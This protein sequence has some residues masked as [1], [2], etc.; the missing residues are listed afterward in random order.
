MTAR[1]FGFLRQPE[2]LAPEP[3]DS[4]VAERYPVGADAN[5]W[6]NRFLLAA[7][8]ST[9]VNRLIYMPFLAL[10]LLVPAR[11]QLFDAW[12][13]PLP[14]AAL[15]VVSLSLAVGCAMR[16]R[17]DA[18]ELR[19]QVLRQINLE[20]EK[21]EL[22]ASRRG[23][24]ANKKSGLTPPAYKAERLRS[25]ATEIRENHEGAFRPLLQEPVIRGI[26][27]LLGGAGGVATA[28]FLLLKS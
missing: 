8:L 15:F 16:L 21:F 6:I 25:M 5:R 11:S 4:E 17:L 28:E 20:A 2:T 23:D 14:H 7:K 18:R 3:T 19:D 1:L 22:S 13:F 27:F 9:S 10:L 12:N 24:A 26:L